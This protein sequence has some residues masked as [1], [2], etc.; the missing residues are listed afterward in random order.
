MY[1]VTFIVA[2]IILIFSSALYGY[3]MIQLAR[4]EPK[5]RGTMTTGFGL[6]LCAIIVSAILFGF[7]SI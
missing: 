7:F 1:T 4:K 3:G 5:G 6:W 2:L